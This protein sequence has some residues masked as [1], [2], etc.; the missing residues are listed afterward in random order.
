M[1]KMVWPREQWDWWVAWSG[2]SRLSFEFRRW[3]GTSETTAHGEEDKTGD[4]CVKRG[5]DQ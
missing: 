3:R 2:H 4:G 5:E 1:L